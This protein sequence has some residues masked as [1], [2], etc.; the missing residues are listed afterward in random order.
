MQRSDFTATVG[1]T[2]GEDPQPIVKTLDTTM[3]W[4][5]PVVTRDASSDTT[6]AAPVAVDGP[7][8]LPAP[9]LVDEVVTPVPVTIASADAGTGMGIYDLTFGAS[10][11]KASATYDA[12]AY[13]GAY[14]GT[15]TVSAISGPS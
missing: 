15:V 11:S 2:T 5:A 8:V 12:N 6:S 1:M 14:A 3:S 10:G 4:Q 13:A 9:T 7:T